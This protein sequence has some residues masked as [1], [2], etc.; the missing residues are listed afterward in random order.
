MEPIQPRPEAKEAMSVSVSGKDFELFEGLPP[1]QEGDICPNVYHAGYGRHTPFNNGYPH[2]EKAER[3][4]E[5]HIAYAEHYRKFG[6]QVNWRCIEPDCLEWTARYG[7][8]GVSVCRRGDIVEAVPDDSFVADRPVRQR[9]VHGLSRDAFNRYIRRLESAGFEVVQTNDI[10]CNHYEELAGKDGVLLCSH[11]SALNEARFIDDP[12]SCRIDRFG[13]SAPDNPEPTE[14]CQFALH[15]D[16]PVSGVTMNCGMLYIL[17]LPDRSFVL[18]DGGEYEQATDAALQEII[19]I[20]RCMARVGDEETLRISAWICTHAHDDHVDVFT[21]FLRLYHDQISLERVIFNFP[22]Y[23]RLELMPEAFI[24]LARLNAFFSD[25]LYLKAHAGQR[26]SLAGVDF[27]VLQTHEEGPHTDGDEVIGGLNDSSMVM[28]IGF[29]GV[30]VLITGDIGELAETRLLRRFSEKTLRVNAVQAAHHLV[31]RLDRLYALVS[32]EL[33]LIPSYHYRKV[34][35]PESFA[36]LRRAV[37]EEKMYF[38][39]DGSHIFVSDG[40]GRL[41]LSKCLPPVGG[42]YDGSEI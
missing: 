5:E 16:T 38:A 13:S 7:D 28:K 25:V 37:P 11:S 15:Y 41:A 30:S 40:R 39:E 6:V 36:A 8:Y 24:L 21:K 12:L 26:F 17:K 10:E 33:A 14:F 34:R 2:R 4:R 9:L 19:R 31:N 29:D 3:S 42:P 1:L 35:N 27:E 20:M 23:D 22:D 18:I 32:P